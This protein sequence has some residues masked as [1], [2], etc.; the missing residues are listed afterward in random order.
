M[1]L[2][3]VDFQ[4]CE[5]VLICAVQQRDSVTHM[6]ILLFIFFSIMVYRRVLTIVPCAAQ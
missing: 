2:S 3:I 1:Y 6:Y 5:V 4:R